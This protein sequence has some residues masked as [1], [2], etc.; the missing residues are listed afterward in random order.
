MLAIE[1]LRL[2]ARGGPRALGVALRGVESLTPSERRVAEL[3]AALGA[4]TRA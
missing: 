2:R 1:E 4:P 3:A